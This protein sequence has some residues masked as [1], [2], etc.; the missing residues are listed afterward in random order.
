M[1][2]P[3]FEQILAPYMPP[4]NAMPKHQLYFCEACA[5][6]HEA[7]ATWEIKWTDDENDP[8]YTFLCDDDVMARAK[9]LAVD[10]TVWNL[11][12]NRA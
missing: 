6:P 5:E 12:I 10:P 11:E 2:H 1:M 9:E 4:L 3:I 7:K 8:Y